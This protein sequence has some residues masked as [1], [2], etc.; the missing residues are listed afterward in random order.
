MSN[1]RL[2]CG[3]LGVRCASLSL[4]VWAAA[5]CERL[6]G[7]QAAGLGDTS[8]ATGGRAGSQPASHPAASTR[9][10]RSARQDERDAMVATQIAR[11]GLYR[12]GVADARVLQAL[13]N[14]PRHAFVPAASQARAYDDTPLPIGHDQTISQPYIVARMTEL[15]EVSPGARVLEIGTGSGYQAAVLAELTPAV[16]TIEIVEPLCRE[17]ARRLAELGYETVNTRCGDGYR[18]WPEAAPFD[19]IIVTCGAPEVPPALWEQL[20]PGGR[21]VIPIGPA[22]EVQELMVYTKQSDGS[23]AEQSI[24]PVRFVPMTGESRRP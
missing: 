9:P 2:R 10:D 4:L 8:A 24:I 13:R 19:R 14:V 18:G 1:P 15:L 6:A 11:S 23:R 5:G 20:T 22:Q 21:M 17:A 16:Y 3:S 7:P 12:D